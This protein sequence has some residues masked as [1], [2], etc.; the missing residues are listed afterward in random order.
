MPSPFSKTTVGPSPLP[1]RRVTWVRP[2]RWFTMR[3]GALG[4]TASL[5]ASVAAIPAALARTVPAISGPGRRPRV[6]LPRSVMS[7]LLLDVGQG[8]VARGEGEG[9]A[10]EA[11]E[12]RVGQ[13]ERAHGG[14]DGAA[15]R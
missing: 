12:P 11:H 13:V 5:N 3:P 8:R 4:S 14:E 10:V 9:K 1:M 6:S 2:C 15:D 7:R